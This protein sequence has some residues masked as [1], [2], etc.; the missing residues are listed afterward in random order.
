MRKDP[1][2]MKRQLISQQR[3]PIKS[4]RVIPH[5][6]SISL[7]TKLLNV[8]TSSHCRLCSPCLL[9][10]VKTCLAEQ[11]CNVE[12]EAA[13]A[14]ISP[15][16]RSENAWLS[17]QDSTTITLQQQA[18]PGP[19][20][21]STHPSTQAAQAA[22]MSQCPPSPQMHHP[23]PCCHPSHQHFV[24]V[25]RAL[26]R[27]GACAPQPPQAAPTA[28]HTAAEQHE[29]AK[30]MACVSYVFSADSR[31]AHNTQANMASSES[32]DD[33]ALVIHA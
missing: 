23:L 18:A 29:C 27:A 15:L 10:R 30:H 22:T 28:T 2:R 14:R 19:R 12:I 26:V 8:C 7:C 1:L 6:L 17:S 20:F 16:H 31:H 4:T 9:W 21:C 25:M 5:G 11:T 24:S 33:G 32:V 13:A 3:L